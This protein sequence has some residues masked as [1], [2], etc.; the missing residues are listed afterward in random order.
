V[1]DLAKD[2]GQLSREMKEMLALD[3]LVGAIHCT[4]AGDRA[5]AAQWLLDCAQAASR[6][7]DLCDATEMAAVALAAAQECGADHIER[8]AWAFLA[9]AAQESAAT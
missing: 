8:E 1:L 2:A 7:I 4:R 6:N 5:G 9:R 3:A